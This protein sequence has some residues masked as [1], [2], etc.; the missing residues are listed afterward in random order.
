MKPFKATIRSYQVGFGDCF[1]LAF[2]YRTI[3]GAEEERHV[4]IDCGSTAP[5]IAYSRAKKT[6]SLK[7]VAVDIRK[8]SG[9]KLCAVVATHRHKDHISGFGRAKGKGP[10]DILRSLKPDLVLQPWT[11]DPDLP[12]DATNSKSLRQA[13]GRFA[14]GLQGMHKF[15]AGLLAELALLTPALGIRLTKQLAFLGDDNLANLSAVKNLMTMGKNE[16]LY[17]GKKTG[18]ESLLPGV[19]VRVMGPPTLEQN[20]KIAK[21]RSEDAAEF[22]QLRGAAVS[23]HRAG[24]SS[25]FATR[26]RVTARSFPPQVRWIIPRIQGSR[27]AQLMELVRILDNQMNNTSLILLF[28]FGDKTLLFPGDAQ[29]ENWN[30]ALKDAGDA[31]ANRRLLAET[32]FYK[33]G[34]HGSRNATPKTLWDLFA[35]KG[36]S[37]GSFKTMMST[38]PGKHGDPKSNTEVPRKTLLDELKSKSLLFDTEKLS[39]TQMKC[40]VATVQ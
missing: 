29:I 38:R 9:G 3:G 11:E 17:Y 19:K 31:Q 12:K 4:L 18:L 27:G 39:G 15:S 37:H 25:P 13:S 7:P 23:G 16:Y 20:A 35:K 14:L 30:H 8:V 6:F 33:V 32:D 36:D 40:N 5:P 22:W 24:A 1:L 28:Q 21:Q 2:H 10:G 26:H 34:H